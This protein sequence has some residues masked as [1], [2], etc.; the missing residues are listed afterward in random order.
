[1][2]LGLTKWADHGYTLHNFYLTTVAGTRRQIRSKLRW[3]RGVFFATTA[4]YQDVGEAALAD[5]GFD[6]VDDFHYTNPNSGNIIHL[7]MKKVGKL[8]KLGQTYPNNA[9]LACCGAH[10]ELGN[11]A[12][13]WNSLVISCQ[14]LTSKQAGFLVLE[15][16]KFVHNFKF[17]GATKCR[18]KFGGAVK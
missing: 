1:M 7:W 3:K 5:E 8:A 13:G 9:T 16:C 11:L 15:D 6:L 10:L 17:V 14:P 2:A 12:D 18:H 4:G